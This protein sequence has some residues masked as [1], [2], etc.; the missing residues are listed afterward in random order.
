MS[1]KTFAKKS[2]ILLKT[3]LL[4]LHWNEDKLYNNKRLL[5]NQH[6]DTHVFCWKTEFLSTLINDN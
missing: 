3:F 4:S 1:I 5:E 2:D 6:T